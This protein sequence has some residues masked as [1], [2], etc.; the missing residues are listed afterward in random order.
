MSNTIKD[1][2]L[3]KS[4]KE[5]ANNSLNWSKLTVGQ[6]IF[7]LRTHYDYIILEAPVFIKNIN[8]YA[9]K[10]ANLG[11]SRAHYIVEEDYYITSNKKLNKFANYIISVNHKY[12]D[13]IINKNEYIFIIFRGSVP[14]Y[15]DVKNKMI[16]AAE[17]IENIE[18]FVAGILKKYKFLKGELHLSKDDSVMIKG[19]FQKKYPFLDY[20]TLYPI[21]SVKG[22]SNLVRLKVNKEDTVLIPLSHIWI[23]NGMYKVVE[24]VNNYAINVRLKQGIQISSQSNTN[25]ATRRNTLVEILNLEDEPTTVADD[26]FD[27]DMDIIIDG[28]NAPNINITNEVRGLRAAMAGATVEV[29]QAAQLT[30]ATQ[31]TADD[32]IITAL[33][34]G[35]DAFLDIVNFDTPLPNIQDVVTSSSFELS[36]ITVNRIMDAI[37]RYI[38]RMG[39][40]DNLSNR[41]DAVKNCFKLFYSNRYFVD[42]LYTHHVSA[43][44]LYFKSPFLLNSNHCYKLSLS[45][46]NIDGTPIPTIGPLNEHIKYKMKLDGFNGTII[47]TLNDLKKIPP[48]AL[49]M[50]FRKNRDININASDIDN[51]LKNYAVT[52]PNPTSCIVSPFSNFSTSYFNVG[53]DMYY[54]SILCAASVYNRQER[55]A[56]NEVVFLTSEVENIRFTVTHTRVNITHAHRPERSVEVLLGDA[57]LSAVLEKFVNRWTEAID[58]PSIRNLI[59]YLQSDAELRNPTLNMLLKELILNSLFL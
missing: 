59:N 25:R 13:I 4:D 30:R 31:L 29:G 47:A 19:K 43:L 41:I 49:Y 42:I 16:V 36:D 57:N 23:K 56:V 45:I 9:V 28:P 53:G 52:V 55:D 34:L 44:N 1:P 6:I 33:N 20:S 54:R 5:S 15:Y 14:Y 27:P 58:I 24:N 12:K 46:F 18:L 50:L 26:V 2:N 37:D 40:Q 35:V 21:T 39:E 10:V 8:K 38:G 51:N 48:V 22:N 17:N 7:S 3:Q 32:F 11:I